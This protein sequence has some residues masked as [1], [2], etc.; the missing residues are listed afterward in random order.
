MGVLMQD[1]KYALRTLAKSPG[2]TFTA[3][4][5]LA[6]GIGANTAIFSVVR[7]VLLKPLPHREGHRLLYLR[8]SAD[9]PGRANLTFSVPEI[10]IGMSAMGIMPFMIRA[11]GHRA[12]RRYGLSGERIPAA[13]ALWLGLVHELCEQ[14]TLEAT[15][16]VSACLSMRCWARRAAETAPARARIL[17]S[18][19]SIATRSSAKSKWVRHSDCLSKLT[20]GRLYFFAVSVTG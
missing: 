17:C 5:T 2:F 8:H 13:D 10:R 12:F 11:I 20:C 9:G 1:L 3:V 16:T 7:G 4:A 15:V 19:S 18:P 14:P 6:L